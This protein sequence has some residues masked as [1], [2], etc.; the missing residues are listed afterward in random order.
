MAGQRTIKLTP[1]GV[2]E[3]LVLDPHLTRRITV[4]YLFFVILWASLSSPVL[5]Q[6]TSSIGRV[7]LVNTNVDAYHYYVE[8]GA[9]T[10]RVQVMG[11]VQEPGLY[12][13]NAGL[14]L[15]TLLALAGGPVLR[16]RR[17][18]D[19]R[20][21]VVR[22]YR[23]AQ[24]RSNPIFEHELTELRGTFTEAPAVQDGDIVTVEVIE[25]SR[26][27]LR[28]ALTIVNTVALIALTVERFSS[29]D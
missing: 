24:D 23:P 20:K 6:A 21:S 19:L 9:P 5:A 10:S 1:S 26:F 28:E 12:V 25:R 8:P 16:E 29:V 7:E 4:R 13:V 2:I 18:A 27:G 14:D 22:L 15:S 3:A 17:R 11:T